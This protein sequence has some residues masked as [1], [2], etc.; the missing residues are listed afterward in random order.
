MRLNIVLR[1]LSGLLFLV[2]TGSGY[3]FPVD[4]S[5]SV[6]EMELVR[7]LSF[8][9]GEIVVNGKSYLVEDGTIYR[10]IQDRRYRP[11]C[12]DQEMEQ[13]FPRVVFAVLFQKE[14]VEINTE[15]L[16]ILDRLGHA[17]RWG[18]LKDYNLHVA[19]HANTPFFSRTNVLLSQLRSEWVR[20]YLIRRWGIA[21][22]RI[23]ASAGREQSCEILEQTLNKIDNQTSYMEIVAIGT[24]EQKFLQACDDDGNVL[25]LPR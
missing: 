16:P 11:R 13:I 8:P 2:V 3:C 12:M 10:L 20:D 17:L 21:N 22:R 25:P 6:S 1:I 23:S 18:G 24:K 14:S 7:F 15:Q 5:K 9:Q 19:L 4:L